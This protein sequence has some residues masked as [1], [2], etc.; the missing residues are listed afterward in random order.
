MGRNGIFQVAKGIVA[1]FAPSAATSVSFEVHYGTFSQN[2][3][4]N[5]SSIVHAYLRTDFSASWLIAV[6]WTQHM[7][8]MVS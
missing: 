3:L 1:P 4:S 8:N 7:G 2:I 6:T 5:A